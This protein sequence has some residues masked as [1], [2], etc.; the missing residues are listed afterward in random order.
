MD[1]NM[2]TE[3]AQAW[4]G[5]VVFTKFATAGVIA[6]AALLALMAAFLT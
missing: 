1:T 2:D 5:W 6:V 4:H 3:T